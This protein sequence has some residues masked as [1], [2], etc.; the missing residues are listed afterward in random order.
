M[1][2][3]WVIG[4]LWGSARFSS[5][6]LLVQ[7]MS[8]GLLEKVKLLGGIPNDIFETTTT[9]GNTSY[10]L[11]INMN[12]EHVKYMLEKGYRGRNGNEERTPPTG[13]SEGNEYDFLEGYFCTHYTFDRVSRNGKTVSRLRFYASKNI[14]NLLNRHLHQE[15]DTSIKKIGNHSQSDICK[16]LY[17]QNQKEIPVIIDYLNLKGSQ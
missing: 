8:K 7:N 5:D 2:N 6:Y 13:L 9:T 14:L 3:Y 1:I 17:Y 12:N 4:F 16:I 15:I 10:R 11:K